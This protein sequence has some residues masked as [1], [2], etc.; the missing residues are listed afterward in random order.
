MR[1]AMRSLFVQ[2]RRAGTAAAADPNA[3]LITSE[4]AALAAEGKKLMWVFLGAPGVGKGTYASRV[5]KLLGVPHVSAGDL[6][7]DEIRAGTALAKEMAEVTG[8]GQLLPDQ[9]VLTLLNKRLAAGAA[10]GEKGVLLDGFPRTLKQAVRSRRPRRSLLR[11]SH[12]PPPAHR[13]CWTRR[14]R[15][16]ARR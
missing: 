3:A 11:P 7:R 2:A 16:S 4:V 13:S 14:P 10:A 1:P 5:A 6:V 12:A 8:R 9:M 15:G